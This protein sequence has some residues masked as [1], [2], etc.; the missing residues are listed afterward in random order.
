MDEE[1][2]KQKVKEVF[3]RTFTNLKE[4]DFGFDKPAE[5]FDEW[6]SLSHMTLVSELEKEFGVSME[7]DEISE[8]DS[9]RNV[10]EVLKKKLGGGK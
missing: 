4:E 2:I 10:V 1:K 9:V 7:I 5:D 3:L 8:M 6:D